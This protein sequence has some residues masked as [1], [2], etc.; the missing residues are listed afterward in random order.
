MGRKS[1][2]RSLEVW[3][4]G[5]HVAT[6]T[7][8]ARGE[9]ELR[10]DPAWV[11]SPLGRPLSLSLPLGVGD[12]PLKGVLVDNY[13]RNLLPDSEE[14]RRRLAS[15]FHTRSNDT[16]DLLEAVGRDCAGA[17]QLLPANTRP[18][19]YDRIEGTPLNEEGVASHLQRMV[20][21]AVLGQNDPEN[22]FRISL[23]GAQEKSA[24]LWHNNQWHLPM[25]ATPTTH[26]VK[27]PLGLV[28][29][30]RV[31]LSTSVENEWLCLRILRAYGLPVA[32]AE[33]AT[34]AGQRA[35]VVKRFDRQLHPSGAWW[36]RLP[37]E[38]FCQALG[39]SP[40]DKYEFDGGPGFADLVKL[41]RMST[42]SEQDLNALL[43]T[44]ILF[45]MLAATDGH[46]KNFSIR[47]LAGGRFHLTPM[48]DV[49]SAWP[50][51]GRGESTWA[52]Q[53]VKLA[54]AVHGKNRHYHLKDIQRRH[55]NAMARRCG[56]PDGAEPVIQKLLARTPT[57][58]ETVRREL[59]AGFP[60]SVADAVLNGLSAAAESLQKMPTQ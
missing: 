14:I 51:I 33:T 27:L 34:F 6:W 50:I 5:E 16:F 57:A 7:L 15:R 20:A 24:L 26:I 40:S 8:P 35:L 18:D 37:Q 25:A 45:W 52:L 28:G 60:V 12:V 46:A 47:L 44:Q 59:P 49:L 11:A 9:M 10:Y 32:D 53:K 42:Q 3:S 43:A 30:S 58:I 19:G 38:D 1:H 13:F 56:Y 2:S 17:V 22:D 4:N 54:M 23:A 29:N 21:P 55:Y 39:V 31:N 48:Y 36:M 41:L